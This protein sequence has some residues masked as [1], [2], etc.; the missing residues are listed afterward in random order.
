MKMKTSRVVKYIIFTRRCAANNPNIALY[1]HKQLLAA[2]YLGGGGFFVPIL[3]R[4]QVED[5]LLLAFRPFFL[6]ESA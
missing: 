1:A 6:L 3:Q 5:G 4:V 2:L